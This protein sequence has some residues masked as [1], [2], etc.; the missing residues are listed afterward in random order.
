MYPETEKEL[1]LKRTN[2]VGHLPLKTHFYV[3]QLL[4]KLFTLN[5]WI[6][7]RDENEKLTLKKNRRI[8][9]TVVD[10]MIYQPVYSNHLKRE[11]HE[12]INV[13]NSHPGYGYR[14]TQRL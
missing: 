6:H 4:K 11:N 10:S 12:K 5:L 3:K 9:R 8:Y 1:A 14:S 13:Q 7:K 2:E